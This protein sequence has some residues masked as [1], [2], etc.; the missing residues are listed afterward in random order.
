MKP[1]EHFQKFI[2]LN[3]ISPAIQQAYLADE[4]ECV[5]LV[6]SKT[7]P[8]N[9]QKQKIQDLATKLVEFA[10]GTH[11]NTISV[12]SFLKEYR[13]DSSEGVALMC[14]AEA[15]I[16]IPDSATAQTFIQDKLLNAEWQHHLGQSPS[17]W[18]NA[19]TWGLLITGKLFDIQNNVSDS[20]NKA[21]RLKNLVQRL[22]APVAHKAIL[23]AMALIGQQFVAG[24]TIEEAI[25]FGENETLKGYSHSYDMLGEAALTEEDAQRF[26]NYYKSA[27]TTL[28]DNRPCDNQRTS[29]SIKLSALHPRFE[30]HQLDAIEE[31]QRRLLVLVIYARSCN[32]PITIDAEEAHRLES[33]LAIFEN[34]YCNDALEKWPYFGLAVQAYQKRAYWV[35]TWLKQLAE[36]EGKVIPVRLVKGAYWDSEIKYA[37]QEGHEDYP[38]FSKKHHTDI[39]YIACAKTLLQYAKSAQLPEGELF[40]PQFATHNAHTVASIIIHAEEL[41]C[42]AYE[43][44]RLHGMGNG[45]FDHLVQQQTEQPFQNK[46]IPKQHCRIYAPVG[47]HKQLLPYLVRRLLENGANSSFVH[48]LNDDTY[49]SRELVKDPIDQLYLSPKRTIPLPGDI[50]GEDRKNSKA[51]NLTSEID[52]RDCLDKISPFLSIQWQSHPQT[53]AFKNGGLIQQSA[54]SP[55]EPSYKIG[56]TAKCDE[57]LC[58]NA[59]S[60]ATEFFPK[61]KQVSAKD[62]AS[63]LDKLADLLETNQYELL[64]LCIMEAGKTYNN[65]LAEIREAVDFCRYYAHQCRLHF[66]EPLLC[67][68]PTGEDNH[69]YLEGRGVFCSISPWNFPLAIFIGQITAALAAGNCVLVKPAGTTELIAHKTIELC[70]EAGIPREAL[71]YLPATAACFS[72]SLLSDSRIAGVV[73][74]GSTGAAQQINRQLAERDNGIATVIAET[75]GQNAM[76]V[77]STALPEQ[78]V[79]DLIASAFDSAGQRCSAC[80]VVFIQE[81]V[82]DKIIQLLRGR[83][84]LLKVGNPLDPSVDIGPVITPQSVEEINSH[85]EKMRT[86]GTILAQTP[87]D[88]SI[89]DIENVES[90]YFVTPTLIEIEHLNQLKGEVFGPVLHI[91]RF[92]ADSLDAV[93]NQINETGYGLTLGIHTRIESRANAIAK[94]INVGNVYINRNMIGATVGVQPFGGQGLSGTGPKAGGPRYLLRFATEKTITNNTTAIGGNTQLLSEHFSRLSQQHDK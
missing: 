10:R 8:T 39:N 61:W 48:H 5:R 94:K 67:L 22:G 45:I 46:P 81:D 66:S 21:G 49:P 38:V 2:S 55:S 32:V 44:Q 74:T 89:S 43:F 83:M 28:R 79:V 57:T 68:G 42:R 7:N 91:I 13:L 93:I 51:I 17:F 20:T 4:S 30:F 1:H 35:I 82:A 37:Q 31:L 76:I 24:E 29:I 75:G 71:H 58:K 50:Y 15:L 53:P 64:A 34:I 84:E 36:Q 52:F 18:V 12:E 3:R 90:N 54:N 25:S 33:T 60:I 70:F 6:Q 27:I 87:L 92:T 47:L 88:E 11:L 69:L 65:A 62:R 56:S 41:N 85:I 86:Q 23:Q 40:Y 72:K 26:I 77:D 63:S 59:L 14:L 78:V 9:E 73:F 16:R 80:R 19:S